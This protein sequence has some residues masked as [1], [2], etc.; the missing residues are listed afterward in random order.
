MIKS[1]ISA[2]IICLVFETVAFIWKKK[3]DG[4]IMNVLIT[5]QVNLVSRKLAEWLRYA[6]IH[7]GASMSS[8]VFFISPR[9]RQVKH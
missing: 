5:D 7:Q 8:G 6:S 9:S 3:S 4:V 2:I 1:V